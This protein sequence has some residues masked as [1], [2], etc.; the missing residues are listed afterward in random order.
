M[1]HLRIIIKIL[2]DSLVTVDRFLSYDSEKKKRA[3]NHFSALL[4]QN[5]FLIPSFSMSDL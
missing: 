5:Y 4:Y 3:E 2:S 1:V